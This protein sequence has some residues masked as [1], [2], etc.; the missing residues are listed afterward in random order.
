[1]KDGDFRKQ[2]IENPK[3]TLEEEFG[4][5]LPDSVNV[6]VVEED[7]Q[8]LYLVLPQNPTAGKDHELGDADLES[9]AG[10]TGTDDTHWFTCRVVG[11]LL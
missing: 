3:I 6:K 2:L 1:M 7:A 4:M 10:G 11:C 5:K 9:V 8:T